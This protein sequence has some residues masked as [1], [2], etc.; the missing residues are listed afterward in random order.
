MGD[1]TIKNLKRDVENSAEQFGLAPDIEARFAR[2][3]LGCQQLGLSYQRLAPNARFPY[4]H[5][6]KQQEEV[7]VVVDGSGQVKLDDDVRDLEQWDAV[8]VGKD[9]IRSFEAGDDGMAFLAFGA[10][11]TESQDA[12]MIP[13]WWSD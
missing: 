8:R 5:H 10:P 2:D 12:E 11:K 4:G 7:Y 13:N 3:P 1:Y 9:T 6:H